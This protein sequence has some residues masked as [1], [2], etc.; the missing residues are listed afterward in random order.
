MSI[1]L[2]PKHGLNP[3]LVV[4]PICGEPTSIALLGRLKKDAE[5]P[6]YIKD[7]HLCD[8]CK[9]KYITLIIVESKENPIETGEITYILR[10]N[11]VES[12]RGYDCLRIT[13]KDYKQLKENK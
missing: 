3:S 10:E 6:H 9:Q 13:V 1:R 8:K 2:S 5:A 11:V 12:F 4:C 7:V